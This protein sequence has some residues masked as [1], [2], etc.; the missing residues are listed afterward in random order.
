MDEAIEPRVLL[1]AE[2]VAATDAVA[3][4]QRDL[5]R[6]V[7][8]SRDVATDDEHDP[9]GQTIGFERAQLRAL[10]RQAEDRVRGVDHALSRLDDGTFGTCERCNAAIAADR[11]AVRPTAAT[12]IDCASVRR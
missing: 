5:A 3:V 9:E 4:L 10:I 7:A 1:E 12:C 8:A 2:R 6:V 11:L